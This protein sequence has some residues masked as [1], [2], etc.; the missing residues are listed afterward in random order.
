MKKIKSTRNRFRVFKRDGFSCQY[1]GQK[2]PH[3]V[4]E[5][6]HIIPKSKGGRDDMENLITAC[7][8]CNRGKSSEEL[9]DIPK[10]MK[11]KFSDVK[12]R[13]NQLKEF[14]RYQ[15]E[16]DLFVDTQIEEISDYWSEL[17]NGKYSLNTRGKGTMKI[18]LKYFSTSEIK[19]AM[20]LAVKFDEVGKCFKYLCGILHNKRKQKVWQNIEL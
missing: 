9:S 12:E 3:V 6:D 13:R 18:F 11:D 7:F 8:D 5:I 10:I 20:I 16:K 14:Y 15:Q 19:E 1:C 17:W 4:L 2:P